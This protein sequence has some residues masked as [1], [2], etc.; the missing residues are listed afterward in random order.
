MQVQKPVLC[1]PLAIQPVQRQG[2]HL[3]GGF[4]AAL[5]HVV[6][7]VKAAVEPPGSVPVRK[8]ADGGGLH[9]GPAQHRGQ[10]V[11]AV[12]VGHAAVASLGAHL[13]V[14]AAVPHATR[15]DAKATCH[16]GGAAGQA[17]R[18]GAIIV[19]KAHRLAGNGVDIGAGVPGIAVAAQMVRAQGV[20]V[21][22]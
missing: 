7:F 3:V 15:M 10:V 13:G 16:Q 17:G 4:Q 14:D 22:I 21:H 12:K 6:A 1:L 20:D 5:T 8:T 19:G 18:V 9:A 2:E 11:A